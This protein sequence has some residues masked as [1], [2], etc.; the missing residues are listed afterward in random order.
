M[1]TSPAGA[2]ARWISADLHP[3]LPQARDLESAIIAG[4]SGRPERA[5]TAPRVT[6]EGQQYRLDFGA[7]ERKRLQRVREKQN[8]P[9]STC[10]CRSLRRRACSRPTR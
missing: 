9:R 8:A 3:L 10:R 4:L 5:L 1:P 2:V 7:S 6:W